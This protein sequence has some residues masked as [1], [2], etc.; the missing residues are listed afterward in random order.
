MSGLPAVSPMLSQGTFPPPR[1][2]H[3]HAQSD[4]QRARA[5]STFDQA[6]AFPLRSIERTLT[7]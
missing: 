3:T 4:D 6:E 2:A 1:A 7:E 5:R